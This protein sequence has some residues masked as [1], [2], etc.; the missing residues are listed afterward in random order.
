MG[1]E[2]DIHLEVSLYRQMCLLIDVSTPTTVIEAFDHTQIREIYARN[3]AYLHYISFSTRSTQTCTPTFLEKCV[4]STSVLRHI[5]NATVAC[6]LA[7]QSCY[8]AFVR[9]ACPCPR[10][11][12]ILAYMTLSNHTLTM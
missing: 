7:R 4:L 12:R 11:D 6:T 9:R 10:S 8:M 3:V 1:T 5:C 2:I